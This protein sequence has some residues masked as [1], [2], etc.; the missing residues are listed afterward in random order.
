MTEGNLQC[1]QHN[2]LLALY[3]Q[4]AYTAMSNTLENGMQKF[5][6]E[7]DFEIYHFSYFNINIQVK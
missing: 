4:D 6:L 5:A 7:N 3:K 2:T 1:W